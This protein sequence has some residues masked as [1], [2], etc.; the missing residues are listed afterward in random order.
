MSETSLASSF[1]G[2]DAY[3]SD[4]R[5]ADCAINATKLLEQPNENVVLQRLHIMLEIR[6]GSNI[7]EL[8][9]EC[10][11]VSEG[12]EAL[13]DKA[14]DVKELRHNSRGDAADVELGK[15]ALAAG[16]RSRPKKAGQAVEL[17][18]VYAI[19]VGTTELLAHL[20]GFYGDAQR[21]DDNG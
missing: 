17:L 16:R 6:L 14:V 4:V 19:K 20:A 10:L 9:P 21:S 13:F 12:L 15:K 11:A 5:N 1:P 8:R 2:A 3:L 7:I 18:P